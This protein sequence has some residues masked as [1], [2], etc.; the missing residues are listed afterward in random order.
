MSSTAQSPV[1]ENAPS[2]PP[3]GRTSASS[4]RNNSN[5]SNSPVVYLGT[6][7]RCCFCLTL[8]TGSIIVAVVNALVTVLLFSW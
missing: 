8:R 1:S 7:N 2:L 6:D 5:G 4:V 3:F